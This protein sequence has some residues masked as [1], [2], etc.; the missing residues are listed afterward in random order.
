MARPTRLAPNPRRIACEVLRG[1]I[2][3]IDADLVQAIAD[4]LAVAREIGMVK[5][6]A[7]LPVVNPDREAVVIAGFVE[8]A[9][10]RGISEETARV[11]IQSLIAASRAEQ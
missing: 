9:R 3:G 8:K 5:R 1:R 2:D 4:R 11:I 10:Q 7:G 6:A